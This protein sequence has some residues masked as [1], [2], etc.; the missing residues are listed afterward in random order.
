M[1]SAVPSPRSAPRL[2][3]ARSVRRDRRCIFTKNFAAWDRGLPKAR[4]RRRRAHRRNPWRNGSPHRVSFVRPSVSA[5]GT[6]EAS[7]TPREGR[8]ASYLRALTRD[9][10]ESETSAPEAS[11][12]PPLPASEPEETP[13][14]AKPPR[15]PRLLERISGIEKS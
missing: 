4:V 7:E 14:G 2:P 12:P 13:N 9:K 3:R 6:G 15:R 1:S 10:D 11:R 8:P 5:A